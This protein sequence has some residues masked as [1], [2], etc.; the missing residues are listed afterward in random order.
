MRGVLTYR[1]PWKS[2]GQKVCLCPPVYWELLQFSGPDLPY[3]W[4][5]PLPETRLSIYRLGWF[6]VWR[7][8]SLCYY[9]RTG[10]EVDRP[11]R[12][13]MVVLLHRLLLAFWSE[14]GHTLNSLMTA[15]KGCSLHLYT[16]TILH[17]PHCGHHARIGNSKKASSRTA[18]A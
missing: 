9:T 8:W 16:N 17:I 3:P 14:N 12:I 11:G 2:E 15:W 7:Y 4:Q 13:H 10:I 5:G 6:G 18:T 1:L